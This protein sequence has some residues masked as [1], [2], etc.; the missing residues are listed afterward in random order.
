MNRQAKIKRDKE[1]KPWYRYRG[2]WLLMSG[3]FIVVL[4]GIATAWIAARNADELVTDDYYKRGKTINLD[5]K[6]DSAAK[7]LM[8]A[9]DLLISDDHRHIRLQ[10]RGNPDFKSPP[11]LRLKLIHPTRM[12]LD[13][14]VLLQQSSSQLYEGPLQTAVEGRRHVSIEDLAHHWRLTGT[15]RINQSSALSLKAG[16]MYSGTSATH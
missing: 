6:R 3:P 11:Q 4:A 9:A 5:L 1:G 12:E 8:L 7:Q 10:I 15:W 14:D 2:P 16:D 13:Q